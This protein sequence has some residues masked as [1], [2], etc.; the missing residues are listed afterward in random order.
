MGA[1]QVTQ[2]ADEEA[3]HAMI[4]TAKSENR[5][6]V[7]KFFASWCRACKAMG[8]KFLRVTDDWPDV[9]FCEILFDNNK[10]LC[11]TLGIKILPYVEIVAGTDGK[12]ESFSCGPSK[13]SQLQAKL[14]VH[15]GCEQ[16]P[17]SQIDYNS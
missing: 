15:G 4:E 3:Y 17:C 12:V 1:R 5:V 16:I 9:E 8:P 2:L 10:K 7:I 11:K 6:V 13:I 14:E